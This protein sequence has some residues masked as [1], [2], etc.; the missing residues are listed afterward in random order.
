MREYSFGH[1]LLI[2]HMAAAFA[3]EHYP[4]GAISVRLIRAV[5]GA[6]NTGAE[7]IAQL[8]QPPRNILV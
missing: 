1:L 8:D 4:H 7:V 5:A 3:E 6:F 2:D